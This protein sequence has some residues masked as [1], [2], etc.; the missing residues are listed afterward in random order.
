V[1]LPLGQATYV[2]PQ[3]L[4]QEVATGSQKVD[5][6]AYFVTQQGKPFETDATSAPP[7]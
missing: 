7:G 5:Y 6:L 1:Q 2:V 4:T 3:T